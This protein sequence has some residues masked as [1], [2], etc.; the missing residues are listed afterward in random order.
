MEIL[1]EAGKK[2]LEFFVEEVRNGLNK[3]LYE[4][5]K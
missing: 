4:F 2:A 5:L 1:I 3:A